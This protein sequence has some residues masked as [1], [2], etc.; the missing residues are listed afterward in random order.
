MRILLAERN[1]TLLQRLQ[2]ALS[3][4]G[5]VVDTATTGAA[6]E[7]LMV[8]RAYSLL[9]VDWALPQVPGWTLC[10]QYHQ[11]WQG[12]PVLVL[13]ETGDTPP[14]TAN[15]GI[16]DVLEKPIHPPDLLARVQAL[17]R[18]SPLWSGETLSVGDLRL[19]LQTLTLERRGKTLALTSREFQCME[20]L[21]RHPNQVLSQPNI[22]AAVWPW[23]ATPES[24]AIASLIRRLRQRL[25]MLEAA[26]WLETIY[27]MGYRLRLPVG[28]LSHS[29]Q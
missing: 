17:G 14:A 26:D 1:L 10:Q 12:A 9:V 6:A 19:H 23:G 27:G 28:V 18:R 25:K 13:I 11:H 22:G 15:I 7:W 5:H 21:M 2:D 16:I 3:A 29:T 20:L 4:V 24:N 8:Q